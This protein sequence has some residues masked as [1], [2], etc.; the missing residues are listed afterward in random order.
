[1]G[2]LCIIPVLLRLGGGLRFFFLLF[3]YKKRVSYKFV[4]LTLKVESKV[5]KGNSVEE[6]VEN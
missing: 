6:K 2:R 3:C 5:G 1:M 4:T